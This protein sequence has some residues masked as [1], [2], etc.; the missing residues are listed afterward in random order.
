MIRDRDAVGNNGEAQ[1][2][3]GGYGSAIFGV[4]AQAGGGTLGSC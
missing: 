1:R 3:I 4:P 2:D